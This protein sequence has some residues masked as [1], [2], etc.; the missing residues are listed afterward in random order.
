MQLYEFTHRKSFIQKLK[1]TLHL[2][3]PLKFVG[4]FI[5]EWDTSVS[6]LPS[7]KNDFNLKNNPL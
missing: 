1:L 2:P 4:C 3:L 5:F 7:N 6:A